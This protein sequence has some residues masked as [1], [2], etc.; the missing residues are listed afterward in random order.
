MDLT[1]AKFR[2]AMVVETL[3]R[4]PLFGALPADTLE[5]IAAG[6]DLKEVSRGAYIFRESEP[7]DAC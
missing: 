7:M 5:H 3:R 2:V 1:P 4:C 6:C